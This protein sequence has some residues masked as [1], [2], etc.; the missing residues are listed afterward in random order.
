METQIIDN[1]L[2]EEDFKAIQEGVMGRFFPWYW[3]PS[4]ADCVNVED[5]YYLTHTFFNS[6]YE[7]V[8]S[9]IESWRLQPLIKLLDTKELLRV[10]A[11]NYI[12]T[13]E[14]KHHNNH[15]DAEFEIKGAILFINTNNGLT[16]LDD[17]TKCESIEN[18]LLIFD[19]SKPHHSTTC[20][21]QDRRVNINV[22]FQ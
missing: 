13:N 17:G 16:V 6:F 2:K 18:R 20:S 14:I 9:T 3:T 21:D 10:K 19:A 11:N 7:N 22:N 4:I 15:V 8:M 12:K 1:A 5:N